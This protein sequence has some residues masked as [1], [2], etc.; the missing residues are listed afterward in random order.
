MTVDL[1][2]RI[3]T[4]SNWELLRIHP[5]TGV[6]QVLTPFWAFQPNGDH[7]GAFNGLAGLT[8]PCLVTLGGLT[9]L[10]LECVQLV[11]ETQIGPWLIGCEI[12]D[13]CRFCPLDAVVDWVIQVDSDAPGDL[14]IL[15]VFREDRLIFSRALP[16]EGDGT[17]LRNGQLLLQPRPHRAPHAHASSR[18]VR[19]Q[20]NRL[21]WW[22]GGDRLAER[23]LRVSVAA[24]VGRRLIHAQRFAFEAPVGR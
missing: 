11:F 17:W 1:S 8:P 9:S 22:H 20:V 13:C 16:I 6:R 3:V 21:G 4:G 12:V 2:G 18:Q 19:L 5:A 10:N 15:D 24:F 7:A 23:T 14:A